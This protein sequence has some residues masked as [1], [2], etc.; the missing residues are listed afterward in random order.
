VDATRQ[1]RRAALLS[2]V[3]S[4]GLVVAKLIVGIVSGSVAVLAEAAHSASDLA[5]AVLT[6]AAV[7]TAARP[8]DDNHPYGHEKAEN[9][10][11]A[12]EGLLVLA[13]GAA[14]VYAAVQRLTD[15]GEMVEVGPALAVMA[16]S[17]VVAA[18]VAARLRRVARRT[19]SPALAADATN[20]GADAWT[21]AG[22]LVGLALVGLTGWQPLDAIV[23][24]AV[25]AYILVTGARLL[26]NSGQ[27]LAD[28]ALPDA[29][30]AVVEG[31]LAQFR[32]SEISFHK[33]RGRQA[34]AKRHLDLH[35]VVP[36]EMT[37]RQGHQLS[38]R[39][40]RE[41]AIALPNSDVLIHIED[42]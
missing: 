16:V 5:A 18:A 33:I 37:V 28:R 10:A 11:S 36:A 12:F 34:G 41:L 7:R 29:E 38:G 14:V 8:A 30:I 22:I 4:L 13:A 1:A 27:A 15:G 25:A 9:L 39:V 35:M 17:A 20:L 24:L 6:L 42:E 40:K 31:V 26:W 32:S 3:A 19:G 2:I 21:S 23:A